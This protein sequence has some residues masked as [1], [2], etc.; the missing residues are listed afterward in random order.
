MHVV[1]ALLE[2]M[3]LGP[4]SSIVFAVSSKKTC[5]FPSV[6]VTNECSGHPWSTT[7]KRLTG[8]RRIMMLSPSVS[9]VALGSFTAKI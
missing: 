7:L 1:T 2:D 5:Q 4:N 6:D 9:V 8:C 3:I